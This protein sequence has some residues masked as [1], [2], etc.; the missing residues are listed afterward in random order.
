MLTNVKMPTI[1]GILTLMSMIY[2]TLSW[3]E[4]WKKFDNIENG[5]GGEMRQMGQPMLLI[6]YA[7]KTTLILNDP[8]DTHRS[9]VHATYDDLSVTPNINWIVST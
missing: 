6:T 4:H 2:V 5:I 8:V 7:M 9:N 1:V 3:V